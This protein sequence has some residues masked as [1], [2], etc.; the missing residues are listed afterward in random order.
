MADRC[1]GAVLPDFGGFRRIV[2]AP[3]SVSIFYDT[4]QGQGC[5]RVIPMDGSPHLPP[6]IRQRFGDS[7]G[8][9]EGNTLVVDVT[10]FSPKFAFPAARENLHLVERFRRVDAKTLEYSVTIEDP[11]VWTKPWTVKQEWSG[12]TS[13]NRIYYEPRCHEGNYGLPTL[14]L[15]ARTEERAFAEGAVPIRRRRT[16]PPT[17]ATKAASMRCKPDSGGAIGSWRQRGAVMGERFRGSTI[18]VAIV[19]PPRVT[20]AVSLSLTLTSTSG[21]AARPARA[22]PTASPTSAASGRR[23]RSALGP[24][25][26]R[27]APRHASRSRASIRYEYARVPARRCSRWAPRP[28]CPGRSASCRATARFRTSRKRPTIKQENAENWIDRDPELKCYLPGIPR[29]M[30]MPYP[31]QITQSTNKIHMPTRSRTP[32]RTIHLD[33]VE[34]PPDDTCMGHSVGRWEGDTLVVDVTNFN[35]KNWFDRAGNFHSEA[36]HLVERFTPISADAIRYEVTIEDPNV[37]TRPWTIAMPLYRRLEP[38]AQLLE[39]PCIEFVGGVH[40]RTSSQGAAGQALGGRDDD[41]RHHPQD[42]AGRP[43]H[44]WYRR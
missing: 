17:L 28:A 24:A 22:R 5:Q 16:R 32:A 36:L 31:F 41:R 30:Y 27:S 18:A 12:R 43:L 33:K 13:S 35:G 11:T 25:G 3:G 44:E 42:S 7:R 2:Q 21:Q 34:G 38:N 9:W 23:Q 26:A 19:A 29:A 1:M 4:G 10:N 20:G 14:L 37:F 15:G 6:S 8:R 39:Y 40:V